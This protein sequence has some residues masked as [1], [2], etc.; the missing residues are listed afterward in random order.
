MDEQEKDLE[1]YKTAIDLL[2]YEGEMLWQINTA[3]MLVHTIFLGFIAQAGMP[4]DCKFDDCNLI[5]IIGGIL[6]LAL[7]IPWYGTFLRNSN[8]YHFRM[9]Q[10]KHNE[11][12]NFNLLTPDGKC[13][14]DGEKVK[15]DGDYYQL[16]PLSVWMKNKCALNWIIIVFTIIYLILITSGFPLCNC[17]R[18]SIG[19]MVFLILFLV[20]SFYTKKEKNLN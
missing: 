11:P 15:I 2:K 10:A 12:K 5:L 6:G 16:G 19:S 20:K 7:I 1:R 8:Y 3:F 18:I 13:F 17:W 4:K 14:A 9:A